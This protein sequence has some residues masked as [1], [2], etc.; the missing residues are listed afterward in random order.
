MM[1][2]MSPL[3]LRRLT[4]ALVAVVLLGGCAFSGLS[5]RID[6][7][8]TF[9]HPQDRE[10]VTLPLTVDWEVTDFPADGSFVAFVDRSP[11]PPNQP[12]E[13][14]AKDDET[15]RPADGC[16][17]AEYLSSRNIFPTTESELTIENLPP[18]PSDQAARRE[19]H[20]VTVVL[21]DAEGK[22]IGESAF[23]VEFEVIR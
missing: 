10:Q 11:M 14:F 18:P 1:R 2:A 12:V 5:F 8:L 4:T 3:P 20:E 13:W 23:S 6:D 16:P 7:R 21:V 15:C 9:V 17:D 22:R 19:F